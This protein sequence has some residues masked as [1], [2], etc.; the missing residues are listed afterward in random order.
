MGCLVEFFVELIGEIFI[1]MILDCL[2][3]VSLHFIPKKYEREKIE[4]RIR[5]FIGL[6]FLTMII[7][8]PVFFIGRDVSKIVK[9]IGFLMIII[10]AIIISLLI[11][12]GI[13]MRLIRFIKKRRN[14]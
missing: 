3:S 5:L 6:L 2:T 1:E 8:L 7:G 10:P 11:V 9:E 4:K 13:I 14:Q 12:L